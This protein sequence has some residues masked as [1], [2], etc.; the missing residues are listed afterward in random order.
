MRL[1]WHMALLFNVVKAQTGCEA[2]LVTDRTGMTTQPDKRKK[3]FKVNI[4][5]IKQVGENKQEHPGSVTMF[6]GAACRSL[7]SVPDFSLQR[8]RTGETSAV[9]YYMY[10]C[11]RHLR[12]KIYS[13]TE[14]V[15]AMAVQKNKYLLSCTH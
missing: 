4:W 11:A 6:S 13:V 1:T 12:T 5:H 7:P 9:P 8:E 2:C 14:P 10:A 3:G 15:L